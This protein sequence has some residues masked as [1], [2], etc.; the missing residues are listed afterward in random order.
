MDNNLTAA[1]ESEVVDRHADAW[2]LLVKD[3]I[4]P[5][6]VRSLHPNTLAGH[7]SCPRGERI[8][9]VAQ[10][11]AMERA[12]EVLGS[13]CDAEISADSAH[14]RDGRVRI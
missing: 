3:H 10:Q 6:R 9:D 4:T 13:K 5:A 14:L 12:G 1:I 8:D 11:E 7:N 2:I